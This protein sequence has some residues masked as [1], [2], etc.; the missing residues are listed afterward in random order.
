VDKRYFVIVDDAYGPA[1]GKVRLHYQMC[2][3]DVRLNIAEN[4]AFTQ[5]GDNNN[6]VLKTFCNQA[7]NME[8][9]EGWISYKAKQKSPRKAFSFVVDKKPDMPVRYITVIYP[10][11]QVSEMPNVKAE[12]LTK[13]FDAKKLKL[14]VTVDNKKT[15]LEYQIDK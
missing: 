2:E 12:F 1:T 9:Q 10:V 15:I 7:Q 14:A 4:K 3:G 6:I 11:K 5:F 13:K 8:E